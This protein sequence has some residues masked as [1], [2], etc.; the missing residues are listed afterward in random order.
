MKK[1]RIIADITVSINAKSKKE[2]LWKLENEP[3]D[4]IFVN[5]CDIEEIK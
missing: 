4:N 2:A 3:L 1:F 5:D